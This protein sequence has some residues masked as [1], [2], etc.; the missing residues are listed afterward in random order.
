MGFVAPRHGGSSW[1]R[2]GT[3]AP[4][5]VRRIFNN[6]PAVKPSDYTHRSAGT[7]APWCKQNRQASGPGSGLQAWRPGEAEAHRER[8]L[9]GLKPRRQSRNRGQRGGRDGVGRSMSL[10]NLPT[11]SGN[12]R[13]RWWGGEVKNVWMCKVKC[14]GKGRS[15]WGWI[16]LP[17][18]TKSPWKCLLWGF[19]PCPEKDSEGSDPSL[20]YSWSTSGSWSQPARWHGREGRKSESLRTTL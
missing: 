2:D 3:H 16:W 6:E 13:T 4:L 15:A 5:S 18:I 10:S 1:T 8:L 9:L 17:L 7:I 11:W 12:L 19:V 14:L 20:T